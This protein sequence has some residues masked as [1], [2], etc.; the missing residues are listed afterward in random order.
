MLVPGV[1]VRVVQRFTPAV[2]GGLSFVKL[3][4]K[5]GG[6]VPIMTRNGVVGVS[7]YTAR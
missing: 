7:P 6:W 2:G 5:R 3:K 4:G 1:T